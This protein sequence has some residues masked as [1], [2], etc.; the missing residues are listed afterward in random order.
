MDREQSREIIENA[1]NRCQECGRENGRYYDKWRA[2]Q[3]T[4]VTRESKLLGETLHTVLCQWCV[5]PEYKRQYSRKRRA[6]KKN[7]KMEAE[8]QLR[9]FESGEA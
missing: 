6:I 7:E 2:T 4:V 9:L 3:L 8:G 5:Q 1:G